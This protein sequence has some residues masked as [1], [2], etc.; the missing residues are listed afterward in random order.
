MNNELRPGVVKYLDHLDMKLKKGK[1][2]VSQD[3]FKWHHCTLKQKDGQ[4]RVDPILKKQKIKHLHEGQYPGAYVS[5]HPEWGMYGNFCFVF[6]GKIEE[7]IIED[8]PSTLPY[9]TNCNTSDQSVYIGERQKDSPISSPWLIPRA[10]IWAG[11]RE[12][13]DFQMPDKSKDLLAHYSSRKLDLFVGDEILLDP[14]SQQLLEKHKIYVMSSIEYEN[15]R[16]IV[17]KN[18]HLYLDSKWKEAPVAHGDF[19]K[20]QHRVCAR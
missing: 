13:I 20:N 18:F 12:S 17:A 4:D 11:F 7:Q 10:K 16:Q 2:V 3:S 9:I 8:D 6:N 15:L 14:E 5:T 1:P 19:L